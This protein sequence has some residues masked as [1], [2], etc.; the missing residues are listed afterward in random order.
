VQKVAT[1]FFHVSVAFHTP[2]FEYGDGDEED[3]DGR[4]QAV[5]IALA[6]AA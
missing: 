1:F 5:A 6:A 3:M 4:E 2:L